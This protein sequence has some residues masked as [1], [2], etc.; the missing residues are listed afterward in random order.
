M[1]SGLFVFYSSISNQFHCICLH[2][3]SLPDSKSRYEKVS[4]VKFSA[5][6]GKELRDLSGHWSLTLINASSSIYEIR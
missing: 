1:A 5:L 6:V 4:I 2:L 3:K